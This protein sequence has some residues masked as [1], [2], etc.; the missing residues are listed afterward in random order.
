M[1]NR[2]TRHSV[3]RKT[4]NVSNISKAQ[5]SSNLSKVSLSTAGVVSG[6][7]RVNVDRSPG[8]P[9]SGVTRFLSNVYRGASDTVQ[10]Y[11]L[12]DDRERAIR[13]K[14]AQD[15]LIEGAVKGDMGGA[16]DEIGRRA[17]DEPG[18]VVGELAVEAGI[19]LATLGFGAAAKGAVIGAKVGKTLS[20][21]G[22]TEMV[23]TKVNKAGTS[24]EVLTKTG[25]RFVKNKVRLNKIKDNYII[26]SVDDEVKP[27]KI[28][29]VMDFG[30]AGQASK[31]E[32]RATFAAAKGVRG[33]KKVNTLIPKIAGASGLTAREFD[34]RLLNPAEES[35]P[36]GG[37]AS[38]FDQFA[39]GKKLQLETTVHKSS[40]YSSNNRIKEL[41]EK[42]EILTSND[43]ETKVIDES[44]MTRSQSG[45]MA[46][47]INVGDN[48]DKLG[49]YYKGKTGKIFPSRG[50]DE[51]SSMPTKVID[52]NIMTQSQ[53][54]VMANQIIIRGVNTGKTDDV[55]LKEVDSFITAVGPPKPLPK[56]DKLG[57]YYG[58]KRGKK[59]PSYGKDKLGSNPPNIGSAI[60]P[61][62]N[63]EGESYLAYGHGIPN[64][65]FEKIGR[66][67][68]K[69][70]ALDST[71]FET[72][73]EFLK[74]NKGNWNLL[75]PKNQQDPAKYPGP[76]EMKIKLMYELAKKQKKISDDIHHNTVK[77]LKKR[78]NEYGDFAQID[79]EGINIGPT[80]GSPLT[81]IAKSTP[82]WVGQTIGEKTNLD[83][84][85]ID[86]DLW[87]KTWAV[88]QLRKE[89]VNVPKTASEYLKE[90][91][92]TASEANKLSA[93]T[94]VSN[95][96]FLGPGGL[97]GQNYA[98][99]AETKGE[100]A[101]DAS[102]KFLSGEKPPTSD[103]NFDDV[104]N[105]PQSKKYLS[106][107]W[108]MDEDVFGA[109]AQKEVSKIPMERVPPTKTIYDKSVM[110]RFW[111]L[112]KTKKKGKGLDLGIQEIPM[113]DQWN[114]DMII[115]NVQESRKTSLRG[116]LSQKPVKVNQPIR[117]K[118]KKPYKKTS[119]GKQT[120]IKGVPDKA[121][122]YDGESSY[123]STGVSRD[124]MKGLKDQFNMRKNVRELNK[125]FSK[126]Y[127]W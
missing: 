3:N 11:N 78:G 22:K 36:F 60:T 28:S 62:K 99:W 98:K 1:R 100:T 67:D 58:G 53:A 80:S 111:S 20:K 63:I 126:D 87:Q 9:L 70:T 25:N 102:R 109:R 92:L 83:K 32:G 31:I 88:K 125:M 66:I 74:F 89:G 14:A 39:A 40:S 108:A 73:D 85:A 24:G 37:Y 72:K 7:G 56:P 119:R 8:H 43:L 33:K 21:V 90:T 13:D 34:P 50:K 29:Q 27:G 45:R 5:T 118:G 16:F 10:S 117:S 46:E 71:T 82:D 93:A 122:T 76:D 15:V 44:G 69:L 94:N 113:V 97:R 6:S 64:V 42:S 77:N 65:P 110:N 115:A 120:K 124:M 52:E 61:R 35:K 114:R 12:L 104:F 68:R 23:L 105:D 81:D 112:P 106:G 30:L 84:F 116:A 19:N 127:G 51:L 107:G 38:K 91:G 101:K 57:I 121:I 55:I 59:F 47:I 54:D 96:R 41:V 2:N 18:R 86:Y 26:T 123:A 17:R 79:K 48:T 103:I 75:V 4:T 95:E 49:I